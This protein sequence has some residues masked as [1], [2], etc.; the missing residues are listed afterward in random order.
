MIPVDAH[1]PSGTNVT[2]FYIPAAKCYPIEI[3]Q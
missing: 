3:A 1:D 2:N